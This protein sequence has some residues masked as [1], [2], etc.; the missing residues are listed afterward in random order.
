MH[1]KP[2]I[3]A[4]GLTRRY[5]DRLAVDNI[6]SAVARGEI[7]GFLGPNAAGKCTTVR[8]LTGYMP[9]NAGTARLARLNV[10]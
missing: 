9:P 5:G 1:A 4:L 2:A 3:E 7:F 10:A 6:H 8:M